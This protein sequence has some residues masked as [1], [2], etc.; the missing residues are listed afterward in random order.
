MYDYLH[1]TGAHLLN[2]GDIGTDGVGCPTPYTQ[3]QIDA[4]IAKLT[5]AVEHIAALDPSGSSTR[6]YVYGYDEQKE[7]CEANIRAMFG[8]I[9]AKWPHVTT[10]ATLNWQVQPR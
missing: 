1:R 7:S 2:L 8:A 5:P 6:P 10:I 3:A 4:T 9:K